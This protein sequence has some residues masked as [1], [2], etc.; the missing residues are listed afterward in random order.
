MPDTQFR[1]FYSQIVDLGL[2]VHV[3]HELQIDGKVFGLISFEWRQEGFAI[4]CDKDR[5]SD[6]VIGELLRLPG[7][8]R[9]QMKFTEKTI[10]FDCV[11]VS[12]AF[13]A[14]KDRMTVI[15]SGE[16]R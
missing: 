3:P 6:N 7:P 4:S 10:E 14:G 1:S 16:I 8:F 2:N 9:C 5:P 15:G 12:V 13:E 11:I